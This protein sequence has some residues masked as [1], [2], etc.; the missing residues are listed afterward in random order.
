MKLVV[1][2]DGV[3]FRTITQLDVPGHPNES[4]LRFLKN[5]QCIALVRREA[6]DK[7][8]W[9]GESSPPYR[10]WKWKSAGLQIG[11]PNFLVRDD[12]S[13]I[14]SGRQYEPVAKTFVGPMTLRSVQPELILPSG[15][16]CSY[17]GLV[18]HKG[19][20]WESYYSTHEGQTCIYLA[21]IKFPK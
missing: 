16:D 6:A 18:W 17:P 21:K 15:G 14:A 19:L 8:A 13:M 1:S 4:T 20:L 5:G 11:G 10:D 9:I 12:G 2:D 3:N 7:M